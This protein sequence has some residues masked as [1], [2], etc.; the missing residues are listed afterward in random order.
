[1]S[2]PFRSLKYIFGERREEEEE[3]GLSL[4]GKKIMYEHVHPLRLLDANCL[5][6]NDYLHTFLLFR[7]NFEQNF[8][9]NNDNKV[10]PSKVNTA[11]I[12]IF[13]NW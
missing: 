2:S 11:V 1:M 13:D 10:K 9:Q 8:E 6:S 4:I 7:D 5:V 3:D 12:R